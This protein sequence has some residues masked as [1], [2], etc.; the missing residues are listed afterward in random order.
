MELLFEDA[1]LFKRAVDAISVLID[2]AEFVVTPE[3]FTLKATDPSQISM[4]DFRLGKDA[5][6]EFKISAPCKI[7]LD[8]NYLSQVMGR[9]K[10]KESLQFLLEKD[11]SRLNLIFSGHGTRRFSIP[12]IDISSTELPS[13]KIE[14]DAEITV[15]SSAFSDCLKDATLV[16]SHVQLYTDGSSFYVK[17]QSSKGSLN[18]ELSK[19]DKS[20]KEISAKKD[21]AAMFPLD[22]LQ[23]MIKAADSATDVVVS[24]K[25]N[26]PVRIAYPIG[27]AS[28]T[29]FLAPRIESE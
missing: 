20:V 10:S 29:Y 21:A 2:E 14:F 3:G 18:N 12:L 9:S 22:Y 26:A 13:P 4:V 5:F 16:S 24:L 8:L 27:A 1:S 25:S 23:N 6:K 15:N 11:N 17:A 28:I 19:K 7:G